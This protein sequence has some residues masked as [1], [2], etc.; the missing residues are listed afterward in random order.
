MMKILIRTSQRHHR[1]RS[2]RLVVLPCQISRML[3]NVARGD[4]LCIFGCGRDCDR[5]EITELQL[6]PCVRRRGATDV[7]WRAWL[8][9]AR[10]TQRRGCRRSLDPGWYTNRRPWVDYTPQSRR[11]PGATEIQ[12]GALV[13]RIRSG[14]TAFTLHSF[15]LQ[16][17]TA[18][19]HW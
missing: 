10:I 15:S 13:D 7:A 5:R 6:S 3:W 16:L 9:Y 11:V 14:T 4:T 18:R 12:A 19:M 8:P 2:F 17:W 1:N